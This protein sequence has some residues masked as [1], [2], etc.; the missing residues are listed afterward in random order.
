VDLRWEW[1][2]GGEVHR[3]REGTDDRVDLSELLDAAANNVSRD[4]AAD[5]LD[6]A[7]GDAADAV[8]RDH[9]VGVVTAVVVP[10]VLWMLS[11]AAICSGRESACVE[12]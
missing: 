2:L 12:T 4:D 11:D 10:F 3:A 5:E 9:D 7:V 8:N 1:V 6:H